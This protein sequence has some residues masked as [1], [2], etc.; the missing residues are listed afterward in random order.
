MPRHPQGYKDHDNPRHFE[1]LL[2]TGPLRRAEAEEEE[3]IKE[4]IS[5]GG[6]RVQQYRIAKKLDLL[7]TGLGSLKNA[8]RYIE[9]KI[10]EKVGEKAS[11][12][13]HESL[14]AQAIVGRFVQ[15]WRP[16]LSLGE[17]D[18]TDE[19]AQSISDDDEPE[20]D[21]GTESESGGESEHK[22]EV[23]TEPDTSTDDEPDSSGDEDESCFLSL[24]QN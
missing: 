23:D 21:K 4:W 17:P 1:I 19:D 18:D 12:T 8:V 16:F 9:T 10:V 2:K 7:I 11:F 14:R 3:E 13:E 6:S 15:K 20:S 5:F 24:L 22:S